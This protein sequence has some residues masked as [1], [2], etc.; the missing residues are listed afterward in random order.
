MKTVIIISMLFIQGCGA[1]ALPCRISA[2]VIRIVPIIGEPV[3]QAFDA[4]GDIVD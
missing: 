3:T 2:D 1:V 4:C